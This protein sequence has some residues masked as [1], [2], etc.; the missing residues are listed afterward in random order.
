MHMPIQETPRGAWAREARAMLTLA[1]PLILGNLAWS[2]ISAT[3]LILLGRLGADT[4]AAGALG[5]N[6]YHA[7]MLFGMGLMMA[8]SP[9]IATERGQRPHSVRDVRRTVRQ[10]M[11][12]AA[13]I[14]VPVWAILWHG[15][16]ILLL[17]G[18]DP[19]LAEAAGQ[20]I[21]AVMWALLPFLL[22]MVLRNYIS[23]LER[24]LLGVAVVVATVAFNALICWILIFGKF[25]LP[26]LGLRGA[27]IGSAISG[28]F[29][30]VGMVLVVSFDRQFRRYRLFGRFWAPDWPRY[31][32]FWALGLPIGVTVAFEVT[33]FNAAVFLMGLIDRP[34]LAAHAIAIQIAALAFMVPFGISQAATV[35]VGLAYGAGDRAG[36]GRA[37]WTA[38]A[39]GTGFMCVSAMLLLFVPKLL[40][41]A[42]LD[43]RDPV[44]AVV[45]AHAVSFLA[46]GALFQIVDGAQVVG[47]GVLRGLHDTRIPMI[48][49]GLGYWVI[50]IGVGTIMAFQLDFK[51]I[52]IWLGLAS[53]LAVVAVLMVWRWARRDRLGLVTHDIPQ[54]PAMP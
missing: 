9:L 39:M 20:F 25:G 1:L 6:L 30:F 13:T 17:M 27:G 36:I 15:E 7:F 29:M 24:P 33:V 42:F 48:F 49:A 41:G 18:Q 8:T 12:A 21:R 40:I 50:G 44:N 52:G 23:A 2:A 32:A 47:A 46:V 16:S 34:S 3:D 22:H 31:R 10:A 5:T 35:R 51:G 19:E 45:V 37:G 38:L 14:C 4:L 26:A 11:W 28:L 54:Q 53:G 43:I